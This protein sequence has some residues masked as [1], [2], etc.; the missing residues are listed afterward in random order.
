IVAEHH[1]ADGPGQV[2]DRVGAERRDDGHRRV[3][4]GKEHLRKDERGRRRVDEE[5]VELEDRSDPAA[6]GGL[7][8]LRQT[9]EQTTTETTHEGLSSAQPRRV[10][11][12]PRLDGSSLRIRRG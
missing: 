3:T 6:G 10:L 2:P 1:A 7:L 12:S 4:R 8:R 9:P 5:V 11:A